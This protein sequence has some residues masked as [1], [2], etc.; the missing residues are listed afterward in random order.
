MASMLLTQRLVCSFQHNYHLLVQGK[1]WGM[2]A[3]TALNGSCNPD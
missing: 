1:P 2:L 3:R